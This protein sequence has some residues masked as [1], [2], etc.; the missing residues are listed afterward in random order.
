M[1]NTRGASS[2]N[3]LNTNDTRILARKA[4]ILLYFIH[5]PPVFSI[6]GLHAHVREQAVGFDQGVNHRGPVPTETAVLNIR[7]AGGS[8]SRSGARQC[9][10]AR[11]V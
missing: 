8:E 10:F 11:T 1:L 6:L 7:G 4:C 9:E 2:L 3:D 5:G